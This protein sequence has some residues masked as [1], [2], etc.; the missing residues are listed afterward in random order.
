MILIVSATA[1]AHAA[2]VVAELNR[3]GAGTALVDMSHFPRDGA[4]ALGFGGGPTERRLTLEG[5]DIDLTSVRAV[6]WRRPQPYGL[7]PAM[8]DPVARNF[9]L[10]EVHEAVEGLWLTLDA[11]WVN[12]P[13]R[14]A[15]AARKVWQL[16]LARD[17]GLIPPRTLITNDPAAARAFVASEKGGVIYKAFQGSEQ[18]WRETRLLGEQE[19]AQMDAVAHAPVIFQECVEGADLRVT[20][21][22][23]RIFPA[24]IAP[25]D[26]A[27]AVD[28]R[29]DLGA[30]KIRPCALPD[31][32]ETGLRRLMARMGLVYGA[33]DF[34]RRPDGE[35][36][37]LEINPGGQWLFVEDQTGQPISTALAGALIDAAEQRRAQTVGSRAAQDRAA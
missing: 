21:V 31:A 32:V 1:D 10:H 13:A 33:V 35:H 20:I 3:R 6:W 17:C 14:D 29:M 16:D 4:L 24:E 34:R 2:A 11:A 8:A 19:A 26:G 15:A 28:F 27:Y 22:G 7:H 5:S 36:V 37:F 23:D 25:R 18:A 12:D 9:A 30:A